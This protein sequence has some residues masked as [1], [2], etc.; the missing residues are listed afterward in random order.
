MAWFKISITKLILGVSKQKF[1]AKDH[2]GSVDSNSK[3]T[4]VILEEANGI[5]DRVDT[6]LKDQ[7]NK[8][9]FPK[10]ITQLYTELGFNSLLEYKIYY[11]KNLAYE[12]LF[13]EVY[14]K[15][16][17]TK[18]FEEFQPRKVWIA[19]F[20]SAKAAEEAIKRFE[21][22]AK[23]VDKKNP[24]KSINDAWA[25]EAVYKY[26]L[27]L[28]QGKDNYV[29][30]VDKQAGLSGV[31]KSTFL[32]D[33]PSVFSSGLVGLKGFLTKDNKILPEPVNTLLFNKYVGYDGDP[34]KIS[35]GYFEDKGGLNEWQMLT[36]ENNKKYYVEK[37]DSIWVVRAKVIRENFGDAHEELSWVETKDQAKGLLSDYA[38][39]LRSFSSEKSIVSKAQNFLFN[40]YALKVFDEEIWMQISGNILDN[41]QAKKEGEK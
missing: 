14:I 29:N 12:E 11:L 20:Y 39:T 2:R 10:N 27:F 36:F 25:K 32:K 9:L 37:T 1:N 24:E 33:E 23:V 4:E 22:G 13:N 30:Q 17:V 26:K 15:E 7:Q 6:I 31:I 35:K 41:K 16:N 40:K 34:A 5:S 38:E 18:L 3:K 19:K 8:I 28:T 21:E